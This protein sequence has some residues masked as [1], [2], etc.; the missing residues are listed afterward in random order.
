MNFGGQNEAYALQLVSKLRAQG[1]AAELYPDVAKFDKQMKYA[2]K[3]GFAYV[4]L[5]GD[6][7]REKGLVS[8]KNFTTGVQQMLPFDDVV[9]LLSM[10]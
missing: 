8:I 1:V 4:I 5:P 2:N 6:E 7:E 10:E 3:R 9:Q